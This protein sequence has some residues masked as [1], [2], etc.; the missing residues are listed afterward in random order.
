MRIFGGMNSKQVPVYSWIT[1]VKMCVFCCLFLSFSELTAQDSAPDLS[2][3]AFPS[4]LSSFEG[5][6][7]LI[8]ITENEKW[9]KLLDINPSDLEKLRELRSGKEIDELIRKVGPKNELEL[10]KLKERLVSERLSGILDPRQ[11]DL[12]RVSILRERYSSPIG[13]FNRSA[14]L[15]LELGMSQKQFDELRVQA[16]SKN[17]E[18]RTAVDNQIMD[19]LKS[20][21]QG[22]S[23][24]RSSRLWAM[25]GRDFGSL[26]R[27]DF[28]WDQIQALP[29]TGPKMQL[30]FANM[31]VLD[32][33]LKLS[34]PQQVEIASLEDKELLSPVDNA[35]KISSELNRILS[36]SQRAAIVQ[37]LQRSL[38]VEDMKVLLSNE[39][40][41]YLGLDRDEA[42]SMS[43]IV[44]PAA[45]R[46]RK[47]RLEKQT[48]L[49]GEL[50]T[51]MPKDYQNRLMIVVEGV[52]D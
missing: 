52:W 32:E 39:V 33:D 20:I 45:K 27:S 35:A 18:I 3:F 15:L 34:H 43:E 46:I 51:V 16:F 23:K 7:A 30:S 11:L 21:S 1:R 5:S 8:D 4:V 25:F 19:C 41:N 42:K 6:R 47:F 37:G 10:K 22:F 31:L 2:S 14:S 12:R 48:I 40:V 50:I 26:P 36:K 44:E 28:S 24:D 13:L 49:L 17:K 38:L 29:G 9:H